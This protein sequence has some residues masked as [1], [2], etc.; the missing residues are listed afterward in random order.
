M[1]FLRHPKV[2]RHAGF[3]RGDASRPSCA[4]TGR[5]YCAPGWCSVKRLRAE[6]PRHWHKIAANIRGVSEETTTGVC[7]LIQMAAK[8]ELLF[9]AINVNDSVTKSK[10]DNTYGCRH[11]LTDGIKRALDVMLSGK[12]AVVCGYG[13][14][15]KGCAEALANE[16]ARVIVTEVDPICA[17]QACMA[18]FKVAPVEDCLAT[19]DLYVTCT[20]NTGVITAAHMATQL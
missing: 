5:R 6:D 1:G 18:G 16:R 14:V 7:R 3:P 2:P 9:P 20:G 12:E 13:N 10:F 19:A 11:S 17:L 15:G 4:A 8:K